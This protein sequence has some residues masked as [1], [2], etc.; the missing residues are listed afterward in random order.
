MYVVANSFVGLFRLMFSLPEV[1]GEKLAF[2]LARIHWKILLVARDREVEQVT[3]Q[4]LQSSI[5]TLKLSEWW[6]LFVEV[7][8]GVTVVE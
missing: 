5:R 4:M 7:Q 3:I 1:T 6:I 2:T 8:S